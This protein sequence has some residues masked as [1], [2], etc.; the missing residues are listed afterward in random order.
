ML[1]ARI[2]HSRVYEND[3]GEREG[4]ERGDPRDAGQKFKRKDRTVGYRTLM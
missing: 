4:G 3:K 2:V 1:V